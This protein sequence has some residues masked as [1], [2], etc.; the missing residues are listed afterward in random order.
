MKKFIDKLAYIHIQDKKILMSLSKGKST[1]YIPGGKR[2]NN[3][4]D[5][6]AL[7]REV[8]E[9]LSV[10]LLPESI[11]KFG[12]FEAQAH[13]HPEGTIVRMTCYTAKF[14]GTLSA[15]SEIKELVFFPYSRKSESSFV[16][17]IIFDDLKN[18]D[19]L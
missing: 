17:H 7:S 1:W 2:E 15:A 13:G 11:E 19:L 12:V 9:E 8:K 18:K 10:E 14:T 16:D 6:T 4:S 3:E 5:L